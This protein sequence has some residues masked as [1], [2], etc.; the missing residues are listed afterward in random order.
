M[1]VPATAEVTPVF[2][3]VTPPVEPD[4]LRPV[5]AETEVTPV[6]VIVTAPV[7]PETLTPLPAASDVTP[8]AGGAELDHVVPLLVSRFP[9]VP[10]AIV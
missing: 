4:T 8:A 10:G 6:F 5:L 2:V 7:E 1:P 9:L 3:N